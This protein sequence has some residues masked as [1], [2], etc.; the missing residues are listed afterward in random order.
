MAVIG[1]HVARAPTAPPRESLPDSNVV[2]LVWKLLLSLLGNLLIS[3]SVELRL[4]A[5]WIQKCLF[6]VFFCQFKFPQ[7][8]ACQ[9]LLQ[10]KEAG[11][12][13]AHLIAAT[14]SKTT[15][16]N[17]L[18]TSYTRIRVRK[19]GIIRKPFYNFRVRVCSTFSPTFQKTFTST[20]WP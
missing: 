13:R 2:A 16:Q 17:R 3:D 14:G 15:H 7:K 12:M 5:D 20:F 19:S 11:E 10:C 18:I 6:F 4:G 8:E 9:V 1:S